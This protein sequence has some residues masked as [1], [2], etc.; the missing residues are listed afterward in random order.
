M[1]PF[2]YKRAE[3][4]QAAIDAIVGGR[5]RKVSGWRHQFD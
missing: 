3:Q 4:E 5:R 2:E 1:N